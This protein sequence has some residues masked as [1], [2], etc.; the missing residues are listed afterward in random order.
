VAMVM[1]RCPATGH[2]AFTGIETSASSINLIPPVNARL[3][4]P[5]CGDTHVWSILDAELV[6]GGFDSADD[7]PAEWQARLTKLESGR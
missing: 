2:Q 6:A 4:C 5:C 7:I 1:I 3:S